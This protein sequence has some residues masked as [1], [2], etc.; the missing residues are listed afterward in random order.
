MFWV[1]GPCGAAARRSR[2]LRRLA[3]GLLMA[4]GVGEAVAQ[5]P[6][7][8]KANPT[9][10]SSPSLAAP[11]QA[12]LPT[13]F[14][15]EYRIQGAKS[16]P[17]IDIESAVYPFLGPG[18]TKDDIEQARAALEKAYQAAGLQTV[19]VEIPPQQIERGIVYLK[20]V[21]RTV[22]RLRVKGAKYSSP[23]KIKAMAPS[24]AEGKVINFNEVPHDIVALNELPDRRV[25]PSLHPGVEAGT[26]DV[27][28]DV[29][30]TSP[31]HASLELNNRYGPN[32]D[33][34]RL[35]ATVSD[36][37]LWQLGH[38]LSLSYQTSPQNTSQV[39][40]FSGYYL[41]R[42]H[43]LDWL[44]LMLQGTKQDSNVS[45]L[46]D[47]AV[48]GRGDTLGLRAVLNLP[49]SE[50]F[51]DSVSLGIDYKHYDQK[52]DVTSST[53]GTIETPITYYPLSA[54]YSATY[55]G[56]RQSTVFNA[57]VEFTLRG[58]GN[59]QTEFANSRYD[60]DGGFI[61]FHADL[62]H[63]QD[64]PLGFQLYGKVQGQV[65]DKPLVSSD[66]VAGG[67]LGTVRG[68]L[69]AEVV[70]DNGVFGSVE[71]RGP[72][73]MPLIGKKNGEWRL[74]GFFDAGRV[75]LEDPLPEQTD[76]FKLASY[77]V[78]SRAQLF[79]HFDGS[80]DLGVPLFT[81]AD[82]RANEVRITFRAAL[83]F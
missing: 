83:E 49:P 45:T 46:G 61:I 19:G 8:V 39:R 1:W 47:V 5:P 4:F 70:G 31:L 27:D 30:E 44:N 74:Y 37:D 68:Y 17:R 12:P 67:G 11:A 48:A 66:E 57:G 20:V 71:L 28:L 21:E 9:M 36:N 26:V 76:R 62:A 73:L 63:T 40:V 50:N 42:F 80:V 3:L 43:D 78:G 38:A 64:L 23:R 79:D 41:A 58:Y 59:N 32:T 56:K 55:L 29:K 60:A 33:P 52:L 35:D 6:P 53:T 81:Q 34:L 72:S 7:T 22:G 13:F 69:E 16:L 51:S 14:I 25:T 24:I 2:S 75:T 15:Q 10:P 77:G 82:T 54:T 65:T 18:R